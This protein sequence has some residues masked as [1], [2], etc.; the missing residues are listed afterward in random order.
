MVILPQVLSGLDLTIPAGK[1]VAVVGAS[2]AGKSTLVS[3]ILRFYDP[4]CGKV[5]YKLNL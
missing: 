4:L 2:G 5:S 3:L 1:V